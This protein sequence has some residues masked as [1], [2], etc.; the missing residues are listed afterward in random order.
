MA[1][2]IRHL[3]LFIGLNDSI[4][5]TIVPDK[6]LP[7]ISLPSFESLTSGVFPRASIM[8]FYI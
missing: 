2:P 5:A 1:A 6:S 7:R 8:P 3:T 4:L